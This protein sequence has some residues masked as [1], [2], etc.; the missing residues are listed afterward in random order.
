M[1]R[2]NCFIINN[3]NMLD[4]LYFESFLTSM[5]FKCGTRLDL[6]QDYALPTDCTR[7]RIFFVSFPSITTFAAL[8]IFGKTFYFFIHS[9]LRLRHLQIGA[10]S[11]HL[12]HY[13]ISLFS[14]SISIL[15]I[16]SFLVAPLSR[17]LNFIIHVFFSAGNNLA[18]YKMPL[19]HRSLL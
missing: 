9:I 17:F 16:I 2:I 19:L 4:E 5:D 10:F 13:A 8:F 14:I 6:L 11:F 18:L 3:V 12:W 7:R 1:K 15:K